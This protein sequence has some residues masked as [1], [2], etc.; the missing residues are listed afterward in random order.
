MRAL[1]A[2]GNVNVLKP[3]METGGVEPPTFP[4]YH[5]GWYQNSECST[6]ELR[7]LSIFL[8]YRFLKI[9]QE[10]VFPEGLDCT[11]TLGMI[12]LGIYK[13]NLSV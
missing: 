6:I 10:V 3:G 4:K 1:G 11:K 8:S 5:L 9:M 13:I 12:G 2:I 7:P